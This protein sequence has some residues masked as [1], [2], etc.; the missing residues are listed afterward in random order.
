MQ[1]KAQKNAW[2]RKWRAKRKKEGLCAQCGRPRGE[3]SSRFCDA[4]LEGIE[5]KT[6]A[7]R[8]KRRAENCCI[9]CGGPR[10]ADRERCQPCADTQ[11]SYE[12]KCRKKNKNKYY[13][14]TKKLWLKRQKDGLCIRCGRKRS[15]KSKQ[16]CDSHLEA[17]RIK[18]RAARKG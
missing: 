7:L 14:K 9:V 2:T 15:D 6:E 12:K 5:K 18:A 13:E 1:T 10:D 8:D 11:S 3:K 16:L 4:C 17:Q